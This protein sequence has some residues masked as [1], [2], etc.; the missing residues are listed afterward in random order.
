MKKIKTKQISLCA[1]FTAIIAASAWIAIPTP[2][3]VN[4]TLQTFAVSL[5]AFCLGAKW[6]V[7]A[8]VAYIIIGSTGMPV[9]SAFTGGFGVLFGVSG[10]F[11]WG[12]IIT[13]LLCGLSKNINKK[14]LQVL[15]IL[16]SVL[17]C[18]LIGVIQFCAVSG[19]TVLA[20]FLTASLPFFVKDLILV[21]LARF[22]ASKIKI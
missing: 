7:A 3:L 2:F 13:A 20:G 10:G 18:H 15:M 16:L 4:L 12:F 21:F 22:V 11:L 6:G 19:N 14:A 8:V 17:A 9:F 1:I 5:A